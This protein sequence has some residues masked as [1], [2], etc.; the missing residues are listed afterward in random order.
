MTNTPAMT[1]E[2]RFN[3][4]VNACQANGITFTLNVMTC[5]R[6]CAGYV[7]MGLPETPEP[8]THL[9]W[10]FGGQGS[11]L[12]WEDG[13]PRFFKEMDED[14]EHTCERDCYECDGTGTVDGNDED[15]DGEPI[16]VPCDECDDG[17]IGG[18]SHCE[19]CDPSDP[20]KLP[21]SEL[22]IYYETVRPGP[23][24]GM[25]QPVFDKAAGFFRDAGFEIENGTGGGEALTIN[26]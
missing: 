14:H 1:T 26:F 25:D 18:Y 8:G 21:A 7:D 9:M 13:E 5:C 23:D 17:T 2:E 12:V 11:E 22:F 10:T 24:L 16:Q 15:D 20:L 6:G 4:A 19:A 3:T